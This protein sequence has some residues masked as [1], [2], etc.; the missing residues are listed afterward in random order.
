[1]QED[2]ASGRSPFTRTHVWRRVYRR[3]FPTAQ[4]PPRRLAVTHAVFMLVICVPVAI[5][6]GLPVWAWPF[7]F[8]LMMLVGFLNGLLWQGQRNRGGF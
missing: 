4:D 1:V 5:L 8:P 6:M 2:N 7:F 3:V